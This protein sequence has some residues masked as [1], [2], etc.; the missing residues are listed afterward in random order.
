MPQNVINA[1]VTEELSEFPLSLSQGVG[2]HV[3]VVALLTAFENVQMN[4]LLVR[5]DE[6][7]NIQSS[8]FRFARA[9]LKSDYAVQEQLSQNFPLFPMFHVSSKSWRPLLEM[10][11]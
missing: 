2:L 10:K 3:V 1:T 8:Q 4:F 11:E 9:I 7:Q 6:H 5:V